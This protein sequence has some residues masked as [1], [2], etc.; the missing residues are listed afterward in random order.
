[1]PPFPWPNLAVH[2]KVMKKTSLILISLLAEVIAT[3]APTPGN[4]EWLN[5][6]PFFSKVFIENKGQYHIPSSSVK[7]TDILFAA[8]FGPTIYFTKKG[9]VCSMTKMEEMTKAEEHSFEKAMESNTGNRQKEEEENERVKKL[10]HT[11]NVSM[12]WMEANPDLSIE[13]EGIT[14]QYWN[15]LDPA[16]RTKSI[17]RAYGFSKIIYKNIYPAIDVAYTFHPT[18]GLKYELI[19]HP[20]ADASQVKMK[21][22]GQKDIYITT[23]G[24]LCYTTRAGSMC[25]H[26]PQTFYQQDKDGI[27]SSFKL[28]EDI[29]TF[30]LGNYDKT[31]TVIIDPWVNST[32]VPSC[33][34]VELSTD[35]ANNVYIY[36]Y[37]GVSNN[38]SNPISQY[39]QKYNAAGV[40]QWTFN[41]TTAMKFIES[42]GDIAVDPSGN[43]F[44]TCGFYSI[45]YFFADCAHAKLDPSGSLMYNF[46]S[47]LL[48]E[49]WRIA[50]NCDYSQLIQLGVG[51]G[52][53]NIGQGDIINTSTGGESGMFSPPSVGDIVSASYGKNGNVYLLSV[54]DGSSNPHLTCLNPSMGFSVVFNN[55]FPVNAAFKD[56]FNTAYGTYGFN[57][58]VAGCN[59]LY[60]C[61]GSSLQ[62]RDLNTGALLGS[63]T[64]PG[65]VQHANSGTAVDK[66]G[67]VYVGSSTGVYVFDPNLNIIA[68]FSTPKP[69]LDIAMGTNGTFYACGGVVSSGSNSGFV[70]QF[71]LSTLCTPITTTVTP[72]SCGSSNIGTA[73]A[74]PVFC[75]APYSYSWSTNPVQTTQTATGLA[76]GTYTVIVTGAGA[77]NEV[78]TAIVFIPSGSL[79]AAVATPTNV[80]C[81]GANNGAASVNVSGG[82]APFTYSW[83]PG[84]QTTATANNLA[85]GVYSITVTDASGCTGTQTVSIT[86]PPA[87]TVAVTS[88]ATTC[89]LVNGALAVNAQGGTSPYSYLWNPTSYTTQTVSNAHSGNY[90]VSVTDAAGC[91]STSSTHVAASTGLV[92]LPTNNGPLCAGAT[93]NLTCSNGVSWSWSGPGGFNS[94]QQNPVITNAQLGA[95]GAYTVQATDANGCVGTATLTVAINSLPVPAASNNGPICANQTL[96][97]TATGGTNYSWSGPGG[98]SSSQQNPFIN[99]ASALA[100]GNYTV[101]VSNGGCQSSTVTA[102]VIHALP[103]VTVAGATVCAGSNINLSSSGGATYSWSGPNNYNSGQQNPVITN[104]TTT[105]SGTY[106]VTVTDNNGCANSGLAQVLITPPMAIVATSNGPLCEGSTLNLTCN[107]IGNV[108]WSGPNN[109]SSSQ[110]NPIINN[111]QPVAAGVYSV[112]VTNA[113]GCS[114]SNTVAVV[115]NPLPASVSPVTASG[116][117]PL[118]VNFANMSTVPGICNW[119]FGDGAISSDCNPTHC[120]TG[121]G[122]FNAVFTLTDQNGCK[123][124]SVSV[125]HVYPVPYADF[126]ASPQPTTIL[127]PTIHFTN[128]SSGAVI[129]SYNWNFGDQHGSSQQNPEHTYEQ[130]GNYPTQLIVITEHGCADTII[131]VI[132]IDEDFEIFVPNAFTPNA[133]GT[134]D[135]FMAKGVGIQ[136]FKML[137]FD[138]WG[139]EVFASDDLY[140]G[141]DGTVRGQDVQQDVYVWK[142]ACTGKGLKRELS[143]VVSLIR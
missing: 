34:V 26:A 5:N 23:T 129:T 50:F 113:S 2:I 138:R 54:A 78:D 39:E 86:Q 68:N 48:Y 4:P 72:N 130:A 81:N 58:I 91:V 20:G 108:S 24:D 102:V 73:T 143:G 59:Y 51:P 12:E 75:A 137:I 21:Y 120:F 100:S 36:G 40:L 112:T 92:P 94:V 30:E 122:T 8:E 64:V 103:M 49:N 133:D 135:V 126:S 107:T 46:V 71:S 95:A 114:G 80:T 115:V 28:K 106:L 89:G 124:T 85:A 88:T 42:T 79:V 96:N 109:F 43:S 66:C 67:N 140:Q 18:D 125:I 29:V 60:V 6:K 121:Q 118:C 105:M 11:Y 9:L 82:T 142:I 53:C 69:V 76:G 38:S 19:L 116:C 131:K 41:F 22:T 63:A 93:L 123:G 134:N 27:S 132:V 55:N 110:Q 10:P 16:D 14:D 99:Q 90:S 3:A 15:F 7:P 77:C 128:N 84:A 25:D 117:A 87:L 57:G 97:L 13:T 74:L 101:I 45:G 65:G 31:K 1:M 62:K 119:N 61:L 111:V 139:N 17:E 104:A 70:A 52:C 33:T 56:G 127:D 136:E 44:V 37:T 47:P 98:F 32:L 35:A 141:W 83:S